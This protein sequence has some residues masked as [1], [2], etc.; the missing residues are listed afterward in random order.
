MI[1]Y[2]NRCRLSVTGPADEIEKF[3]KS[4]LGHPAYYWIQEE[5]FGKPFY[6]GGMP[7]PL[8]GEKC[9]Q[10]NLRMEKFIPNQEKVRCLNALYPVPDYIRKMGY[11]DNHMMMFSSFLDG[12]HKKMTGLEWQRKYWG[13]S[14]RE[15]YNV[16]VIEETLTFAMYEF[17]IHPHFPLEWLIYVS[18]LFPNLQFTGNYEHSFRSISEFKASNNRVI[19]ESIE[20]SQDKLAYWVLYAHICGSGKDNRFHNR[21]LQDII[22]STGDY[23]GLNWAINFYNKIKSTND[24]DIEDIAADQS[25]DKKYPIKALSIYLDD[26]QKSFANAVVTLFKKEERG[27]KEFKKDVDNIKK[28]LD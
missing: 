17:I 11:R 26:L 18:S 25:L 1:D 13:L 7:K 20:H 5:Q 2:I 3:C 6:M 27:V 8:E 4:F 24:Q 9:D 10:Y 19:C 28:E 12:N 16:T 14:D 21:T 15:I 22:E 23:L